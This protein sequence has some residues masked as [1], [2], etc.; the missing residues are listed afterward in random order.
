[1]FKKLSKKVESVVPIAS[2]IKEERLML[3]NDRRRKAG[4]KRENNAIRA[5]YQKFLMLL[6]KENLEVDGHFTSFEVEMLAEKTFNSRKSGL[7][8]E[9]YI[10]VRYGG[11]TFTAEE[12]SRVRGLY[13]EI[14]KEIE[15]K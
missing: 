5:I 15:Q 3:K 13:K 1:L 11:K 14:K 6:K 10:K 9:A 2:G 4:L 12:V 8:R 7:L